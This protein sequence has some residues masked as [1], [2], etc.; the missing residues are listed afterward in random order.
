MNILPVGAEVH[1]RNQPDQ[2]G[3]ILSFIK[4]T[5]FFP[6][7]DI[8]WPDNTYTRS[9]G[10]NLILVYYEDFLERIKDRMG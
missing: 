2:T 10:W 9:P 8:A 4:N 7:Y 3:R 6:W 5:E 1:I